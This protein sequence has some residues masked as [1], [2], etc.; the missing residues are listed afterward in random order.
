[1]TMVAALKKDKAADPRAELRRAILDAAAARQQVTATEGA[2]ERARELVQE[3]QARVTAAGVAVSAARESHAQ[4]VADAIAAGGA[5]TSTSLIRIA[6]DHERDATDDL[7]AA[8]DALVR[9]EAN[10][11]LLT[12]DEAV[13]R[14]TVEREL[15]TV[16][17]PTLRALIEEARAHRDSYLRA[18]VAMVEVAGLFDAW[19]P[20]RK[21]SSFVGLA[22]NADAHLMEASAAKWRSALAALRLDADFDLPSIEGN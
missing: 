18:Q 1:M 9:L 15:T 14:K 2:I 4:R 21:E 10:Q 11:V 17:E 16:L 3:A 8:K 12:A 5:P 19:H 7:A 6:Q 13:A 20:L 22:S